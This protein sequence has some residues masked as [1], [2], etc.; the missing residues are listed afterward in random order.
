[1]RGSTDTET[2]LASVE[3]LEVFGALPTEAAPT[4]AN[5]P[6][7]TWPS[8]GEVVFDSVT[9]RYRPHLKPVLRGVSVT[10]PG[11]TT[12]GV[13]GRTG[14]GKSS[15]ML[16]LFRVLELEK[17]PGGGG[18]GGVGP[19]GRILIDGVDIA[20]VGLDELRSRL[21]I[22]PQVSARGARGVCARGGVK[23]AARLFALPA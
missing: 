1:M 8:A 4:S 20:T 16:T 11:G 17:A 21:A 9:A 19:G 6:P 7:P 12:L 23:V 14:S 13:C 5:P 22:I 10:V 3:R 18:G 15:L 2:Y